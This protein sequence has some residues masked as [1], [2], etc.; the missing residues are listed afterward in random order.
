MGS[1]ISTVSSNYRAAAVYPRLQTWNIHIHIRRAAQ[2]ILNLWRPKAF[3]VTVREQVKGTLRRKNTKA[4]ARYPQG[5]SR[6]TKWQQC[7]TRDTITKYQEDRGFVT[8]SNFT[9]DILLQSWRKYLSFAHVPQWE[10]S[11]LDG[12]RWQ[13][14]G[15]DQQSSWWPIGTTTQAGQPHNKCRAMVCSPYG[16]H[17]TT[18]WHGY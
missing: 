2:D 18:L 5:S 4:D 14:Q 17:G 9:A 10:S 1:K 8:Q 13:G 15:E 3:E 12:E 7:V 11:K 6:R 16:C